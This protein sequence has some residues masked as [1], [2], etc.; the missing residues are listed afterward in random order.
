MEER[1]NKLEADQNAIIK[2]LEAK[3]T[4]QGNIIKEL[5]AN[6]TVRDDIIKAQEDTIKELKR[7]TGI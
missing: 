4:I 5:K 2:M 6:I 1:M 3:I 7:S